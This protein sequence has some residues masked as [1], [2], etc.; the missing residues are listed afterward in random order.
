MIV[1]APSS[2]SSIGGNTISTSWPSSAPA[3]TAI[4]VPASATWSPE[5]K[6]MLIAKSRLPPRAMRTAAQCSGTL[7]TSGTMTIPTKTVPMPSCSIVGSI[8][9]TSSSDIAPVTT[10]VIASVI[11]AERALQRAAAL[12]AAPARAA[13][14]SRGGRR[15]RARP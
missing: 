11:S 9:E 10:A 3:A 12:V 15:R 13:S 8:A 4:A 7:P 2:A 14:T 5:L 6:A 1:A